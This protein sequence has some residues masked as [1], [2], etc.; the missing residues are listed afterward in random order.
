[1]F[2]R[3]KATVPTQPVPG[4]PAGHR[5]EWPGTNGHRPPAGQ[6]PARQPRRVEAA[7]GAGEPVQVSPACR[8]RAHAGC[9]DRLDAQTGRRCGCRCHRHAERL[10]YL[11][12][13]L[14]AS[15]GDCLKFRG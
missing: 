10:A 11:F 5:Y 6:Q 1:M 8:A 14:A 15:A 4:G 2:E 13:L 3:T 9:P 7:A 12:Y